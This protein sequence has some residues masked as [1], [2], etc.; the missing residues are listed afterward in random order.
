MRRLCPIIH[1]R[2]DLGAEQ[3]RDFGVVH[4]LYRDLLQSLSNKQVR[5]VLS[6]SVGGPER[7]LFAA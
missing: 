4:S 7:L 5:P 2:L 3:V 6:T 1:C